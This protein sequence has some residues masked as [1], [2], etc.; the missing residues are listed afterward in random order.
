MV[1]G[2]IKTQFH[3][4]LP[5]MPDEPNPQA[6]HLKVRLLLGAQARIAK[7]YSRPAAVFIFLLLKS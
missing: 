7:K 4:A 3:V 6:S 1:V 2:A 5:M